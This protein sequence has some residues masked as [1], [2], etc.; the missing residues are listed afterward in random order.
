MQKK[1]KITVEGVAYEVLVEDITHQN[2]PVKSRM[3]VQ[4]VIN[5]KLDFQHESDANRVSPLNGVVI[6]IFVKQGQTVEKG[7]ALIT[8]ESMKI[9][10]TLTAHR[11]GTITQIHVEAEQSV[12][13]GQILFTIGE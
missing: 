12:F 9:I 4:R 3:P 11:S 1:L 8:I 7:S 10:N 2:K 13:E 5:S 6:D